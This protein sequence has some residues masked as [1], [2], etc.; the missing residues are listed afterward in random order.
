MDVI[1]LAKLEKLAAAGIEL[2]PADLGHYYIF[3]RDGFAALVERRDSGFGAIGSA[4]LLIEQGFA[5]LL[6][7]DNVPYFVGKGFEQ[8]AASEQVQMLRS[9]EADLRGALA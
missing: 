8:P 1:L 4:G 5:A 6:W 3:M 2:L 7:R 9:F